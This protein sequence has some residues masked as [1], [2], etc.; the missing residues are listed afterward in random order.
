MPSAPRR[1]QPADNRP[2]S[3]SR[4]SGSSRPPA[5]SRGSSHDRQRDN[6]AESAADNAR[7]VVHEK[8]LEEAAPIADM[9]YALD[10]ELAVSALLGGVYATCDSGRD[11]AVRGFAADFGRYLA[12]RRSLQARAVRA[13]LAAVLPG[14][15]RRPSG[16]A[17][18]PDW[19]P[20][21]GKVRCTGA[22]AVQ[23]NFGDQTQ[24]V[25][26]FSYDKPELGGPD[27]AVSFL[28]DHNLGYTK[29]ISIGVPAEQVVRSW[30]D[31]AERDR[32]ITIAE[33]E[34]AELRGSVMAYLDRTDSLDKPPSGRYAEERVFAL[35]RLA[36]L[37]EPA[38]PVETP[39]S[40]AERDAV[41]ADFLA[42]P[43]AAIGG[44]SRPDTQII[45]W[46]AR[47]A[48]D[49][50]IGD[51]AGD[52]LRWSPTAVEL[53]LLRWAPAQ[54]SRT[55]QAAPWLPEVLDAFIAYAGR[56]KGQAPEAV[57]AS[58]DAVTECAAPY[59]DAMTGETLGEP[60]T[61]MLARMVA[62]GVD[63]MNEDEVLKWVLAD[64][65]RRGL[66]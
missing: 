25:A 26:T 1:R 45:S 46:G 39:L 12:K 60:V 4:Q 33:V 37:P 41:V 57:A 3:I 47:A 62:D 27:H 21:A 64:R 53:M 22:W 63:P 34:P 23:D 38:G 42:A 20:A 30:Q 49:F 58:R 15:T 43:E 8:I 66:D 54:L 31:E 44:D 2:R 19:A 16:K 50:A 14:E 56:V 7:E 6:A 28:L 24:Y 11:A 36:V 35:A 5:Q 13:G 48:V 61:E 59:T 29:D 52:P 65:A 18:A 55:H 32:D 17:A 9:E 40:D 51:N 10:A